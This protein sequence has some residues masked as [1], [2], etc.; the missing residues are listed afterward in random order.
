LTSVIVFSSLPFDAH[1][2]EFPAAYQF[3]AGFLAM[4]AQK[5]F[6]RHRKDLL[7]MGTQGTDRNRFDVEAGA[8]KD[9]T[10]AEYLKTECKRFRH[11]RSQR[12]H[13]QLYER[14][15]FES[16]PLPFLPNQVEKA[17]RDGQFMHDSFPHFQK[18]SVSGWEQTYQGLE[19]ETRKRD[20]GTAFC[21]TG[22]GN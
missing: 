3:H 1:Q 16:V 2:R 17:L 5:D 9:G 12:P 8:L 19:W 11:H 18:M 13:L 15:G 6:I 10:P 4:W 20:N 21:M 14:D 7:T 22:P